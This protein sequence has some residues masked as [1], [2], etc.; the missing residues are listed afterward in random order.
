MIHPPIPAYILAGGRSTRFGSDKARAL[1]QGE[2][3]IVRQARQLEALSHPVVVVAAHAGQYGDLGLAT[4]ADLEPGQGPVG[5][6]RTALEHRAEGWLILSSCD[7][8]ILKPGWLECLIG[9]A[10]REA[11]S[12]VAYRTDR[13]QP[14]L[15]LYHTRLLQQPAVWKRSL[16]RVLAAASSCPLTV[17]PDWPSALQANTLE[18]LIRFAERGADPSF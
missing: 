8:V 7:L 10:S 16:Q 12:V 17:P 1:F 6:L 5:G 18:E 11:V 4:I 15:G 3:L 9:I 14:F 13:W 2:A